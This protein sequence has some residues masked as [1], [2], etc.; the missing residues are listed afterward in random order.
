MRRYRKIEFLPFI[1]GVL[2]KER[3]DEIKDR[4]GG[5]P[6]NMDY[7]KEF[8]KGRGASTKDKTWNRAKH[9]HNCCLSKVPWRHRAICPKLKIDLEN[10]GNLKW[11]E[12]EV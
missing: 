5:Q 8:I 2:T 1:E 12:F 4:V 3:L 10:E 7:R 9:L 11:K 6:R